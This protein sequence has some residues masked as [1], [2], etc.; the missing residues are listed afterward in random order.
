MPC[1][2]YNIIKNIP[3]KD[4]NKM[5]DSDLARLHGLSPS[6]IGLFH[7]CRQPNAIRCN[8][9]HCINHVKEMTK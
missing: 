1:K 6:M 8:R 3:R 7:V 4:F 9:E 2:T 5:K